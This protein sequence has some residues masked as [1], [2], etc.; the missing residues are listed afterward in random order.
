[1]NW[2]K[3]AN[4]FCWVPAIIVVKISWHDELEPDAAICP[5]DVHHV[6][7]L[8]KLAHQNSLD[9]LASTFPHLADQPPS[10]P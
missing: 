7:D 1:M 5:A 8:F 6:S 10:P 9:G 2:L 4:S 3:M